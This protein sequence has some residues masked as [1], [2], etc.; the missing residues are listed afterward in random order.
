MGLISKIKKKFTKKIKTRINGFANS[1]EIHPKNLLKNVMIR[2]SGNGNKVILHE[3][4]YV[5]P[6][7]LTIEIYA[8]NC[9][10]EIGKNTGFSGCE[11]FLWD[12]NSKVVLG[13]D[14]I[15]AKDT[16]I[17]C[18]DFH[19]LIEYGTNRPVNKGREVIVGNHVWLGNSVKVLKNTHIASDIVVGADSIVSKNLDVSHSVCAGNPAV[20]KKENISWAK[21]KFD[22]KN[23][24]WLDEK[25]EKYD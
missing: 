22:L 2:I 8:N 13:T 20:L 19:S 10:V 11:I 9:I 7:Y 23:K 12:D 1:V 18:T 21:E 24:M 17:Y 5:S 15:V 3:D 25:G 4:T 16:K 6:G 14:C